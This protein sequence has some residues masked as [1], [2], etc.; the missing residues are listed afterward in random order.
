MEAPK[1]MLFVALFY[2]LTV[3]MVFAGLIAVLMIILKIRM[4]VVATVVFWFYWA[5]VA[6]IYMMSR[7]LAEMLG[8]KKLFLGFFVTSS[9]LT[10]LSTILLVLDQ[11]G[12]IAASP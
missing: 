7:K 8:M 11:L 6:S 3:V 10:A 1:K 2:P 5:C 9:A 12:V 4:L